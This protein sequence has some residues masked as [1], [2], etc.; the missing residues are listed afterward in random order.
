MFSEFI[1][2][3]EDQ[4][5]LVRKELLRLR[6]DRHCIKQQSYGNERRK[7]EKWRES[8]LCCSTLEYAHKKWA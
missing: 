3:L 1:N 4:N 7:R 8:I 5:L 6:Q 2:G